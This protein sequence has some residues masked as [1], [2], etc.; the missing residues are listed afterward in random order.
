MVTG[1]RA[2]TVGG[3]HEASNQRREFGWT[4]P[5]IRGL[6]NERVV[7]LVQRAFPHG[8]PR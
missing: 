1:P 4:D 5:E 7:R 8:H 6:S 2:A 3:N